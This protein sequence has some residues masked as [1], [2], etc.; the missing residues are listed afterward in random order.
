V[1]LSVIVAVAAN[2]VI[3]RGNAL[4]WRLPGDLKRF[5]RLTMGHHLLMGR[6]TFESIGRPLPGRTSIVITRNRAYTT[7]SG[8]LVAHDVTTA[9]A[10]VSDDDS[11]AFV[12]GGAE[13]YRLTL[14]LADRLYLTEIERAAEGD[15]FFPTFEQ[16]DWELVAN[17]PGVGGGDEWPHRYLTYVRRR[18]RGEPP[19][20]TS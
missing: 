20:G 18:R 2:G 6:R 13:I 14:P 19:P 7:P 1:T 3:G 4:P 5:K 10:A 12:I 9:L 15:V 11:E 8:V 16:D 17:D